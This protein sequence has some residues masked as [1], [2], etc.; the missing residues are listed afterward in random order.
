MFK[1]IKFFEHPVSDQLTRHTIWLNE[2]ARSEFCHLFDNNLCDSVVFH[3][4][5]ATIIEEWQLICARDY[6][7]ETINSLQTFGT[8]FTAP[9]VG[10]ISDRHGRK[11]TFMCIRCGLLR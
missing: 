2:S 10:I 5:F 8:L 4:Q 9:L 11:A 3:A 6:I 7:P 1:N